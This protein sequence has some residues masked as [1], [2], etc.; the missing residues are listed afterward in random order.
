MQ[1]LSVPLYGK[2]APKK[3]AS[4]KT[5]Q[6]R[7]DDALV[8]MFPHYFEAKKADDPF[9]IQT[10]IANESEQDRLKREADEAEKRRIKNKKKREG[11]CTAAA[12]KQEKHK[13]KIVRKDMVAMVAITK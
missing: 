6:E 8:S 7:A 11:L 5:S 9:V 2:T 4:K 1:G 13:K 10:A 12:K 3:P